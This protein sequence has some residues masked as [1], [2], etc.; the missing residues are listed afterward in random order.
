M[1]D[2]VKQI[3]LGA[4]LLVGITMVAQADPL[5]RAGDKSAASGAAVPSAARQPSG[6]EVSALP[7]SDATPTRDGM[8]LPSV[9][10]V[11]PD[12]SHPY[13]SGVAPKVSPNGRVRAEHYLLPPDYV[14]NIAMHPYTSGVGLKVG[15]NRALRVEHYEVPAGYDRDL[16]KHPYSSGVGPTIDAPRNRPGDLRPVAVSHNNH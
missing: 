9:S 13:W 15:P 7:P 10:V 5:P 14:T 1:P 8:A 6:T 11:A 12:Y 4:V 16:A 3:V 2:L